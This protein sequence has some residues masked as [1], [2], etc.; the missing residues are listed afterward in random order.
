MTHKHAYKY[1][2]SFFLITTDS[3]NKIDLGLHFEETL[4]ALLPRIKLPRDHID[5]V[6]FIKNF[7]Y[8]G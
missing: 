3:H 7:A 2:S 6:V 8:K 5:F 4:T 1:S